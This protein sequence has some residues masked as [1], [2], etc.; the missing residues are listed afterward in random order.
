M[1]L[2]ESQFYNITQEGQIIQTGGPAA[3]DSPSFPPAPFRKNRT[4]RDKRYVLNN[5]NQIK[6][7][8]RSFSVIRCTQL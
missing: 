5:C 2:K 7:N 1:R 3:P 4:R 6:Y 8:Y